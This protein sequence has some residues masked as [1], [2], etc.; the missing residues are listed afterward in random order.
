MAKTYREYDIKR[1]GFTD[2]IKIRVY[3]TP[4]SMRKGYLAE[5]SR[6]NGRKRNTEA[7]SDSVGM[8][9]S[10]CYMTSDLIEGRFTGDV[11]GIMFLNEK[12]ITPEVIVHEC[13]HVTFQH[14]QDI[15]RFKMDYSNR[16]KT[17]EHEERFAYYLGWLAAEVLQLLKKERLLR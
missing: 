9:Y 10:P 11:C 2:G 13:V 1:P 14:E 8:F 4:E 16:G 7:L 12:F 6:F 15:A 5:W 17:S 3:K